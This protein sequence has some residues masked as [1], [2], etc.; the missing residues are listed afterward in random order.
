MLGLQAKEAVLAML[1]LAQQAGL[2]VVEGEQLT[3]LA[4]PKPN[5]VTAA[6]LW[7]LCTLLLCWWTAEL[8]GR[9]HFSCHTTST[10][11]CESSIQGNHSS[12]IVTHSNLYS[13]AY[14]DYQSAGQ[15]MSVQQLV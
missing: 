11:M 6:Y 14:D 1:K 4:V 12:L 9:H 13:P 8:L 2:Q 3:G 5:Q 15:V 7:K 10:H